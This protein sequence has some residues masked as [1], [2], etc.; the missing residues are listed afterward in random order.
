MCFQIFNKI[1]TELMANEYV[2]FPFEN[3]T[4][5]VDYEFIKLTYRHL[6][7]LTHFLG[8]FINLEY[9]DGS[10]ADFNA[11]SEY[12]FSNKNEHNKEQAENVF[13]FCQE[14]F[15][16]L[17]YPKIV[18]I[19][20]TIPTRKSGQ[21]NS[22][23]T[24]KQIYDYKTNTQREYLLLESLFSKNLDS[25]RN[26]K[27]YKEKLGQTIESLNYYYSEKE[28]GA[29][30]GMMHRFN[31][32]ILNF[33][34]Y[35][36]NFRDVE[37]VQNAEILRYKENEEVERAWETS[38]SY[39]EKKSLYVDDL[40][41]NALE[42]LTNFVADSDE[43]N[44]ENIIHLNDKT[45]STVNKINELY[46]PI[47]DQIDW[48][49]PNLTLEILEDIEEKIVKLKLNNEIYD[50]DK[51]DEALEYI[52][53]M[54]NSAVTISKVQNVKTTSVFIFVISFILM[55]IVFVI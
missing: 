22:L 25:E 36:I 3:T 46:Q 51:L 21:K 12:K 53:S 42:W 13:K 7:N 40:S 29:V 43:L 44:T 31:H 48:D 18:N 26:M 33:P 16:N 6:L 1:K 20:D 5:R 32:L 45:F 19:F 17:E 8:I 55:F 52:E 23:P 14:I 4:Q 54:K 38:Y 47:S 28:E 39:Y 35:F 37:N 30:Y 24:K 9:Q 49:K 15:A 50:L 11:W 41:D 2:M 27:S 34:N 10:N